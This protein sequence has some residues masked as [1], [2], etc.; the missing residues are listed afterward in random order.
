MMLSYKFV[1]RGIFLIL[2]LHSVLKIKLQGKEALS[3]LVFTADTFWESW[4]QYFLR[5]LNLQ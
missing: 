3:L 5:R 2:I 4:I 1:G